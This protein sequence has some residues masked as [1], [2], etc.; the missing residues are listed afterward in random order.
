MMIDFLIPIVL[1]GWALTALAW[2]ANAMSNRRLEQERARWTGFRKRAGCTVM[3]PGKGGAPMSY[4]LISHDSGATW[5]AME[6]TPDWGLRAL[7]LADDVWPG[8]LAHLAA[9]DALFGQAAAK[10]PLDLSH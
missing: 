6:H 4:I 10:G 3:L 1:I 5:T 2:R 8:L 9:K 7:G